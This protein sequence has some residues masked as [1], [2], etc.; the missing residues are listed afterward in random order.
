MSAFTDSLT[1]TERAAR[2]YALAE[3]AD[4][5]RDKTALRA[6][7]YA[8]ERIARPGVPFSLE[9][10]QRDLDALK[11]LACAPLPDAQE[12]ATPAAALP[13]RLATRAVWDREESALHIAF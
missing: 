7:A 13:T 10:I 12:A 6:A 1:P 11:S 4:D 5:V 8:W 2:C 9:P 3:A